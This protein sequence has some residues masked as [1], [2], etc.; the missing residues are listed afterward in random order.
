[1][2]DTIDAQLKGFDPK[3]LLDCALSPEAVKNGTPWRGK[4]L[5]GVPEGAAYALHQLGFTLTSTSFV[6]GTLKLDKAPA[7]YQL[8]LDGQK[9]AVGELSLEPG[10]HDLV[11]KYLSDARAEKPDSLELTF[12]SSSQVL[13]GLPNN[14]G[15]LYTVRVVYHQLRVD[16]KQLIKHILIA[17]GNS[18]NIT[19]GVHAPGLQRPGRAG[20]DLPLQLGPRRSCAAICLRAASV[21]H[22]TSSSSS[23]M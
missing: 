20:A 19:H 14:F 4:E 7:N 9:A 13:V 16:A 1:M 11:I 17:L 22:Q 5:P 3:S 2:L 21:L 12:E 10:D 8:L 6:K 18:R 15:R 23:S